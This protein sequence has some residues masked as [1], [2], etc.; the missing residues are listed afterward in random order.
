MTLVSICVCTFRRPCVA[1]TLASLSSLRVP[2][3]IVL[4]IV[5]IDNDEDPSALETVKEAARVSALAVRYVHCP[6]SNIS[7]ARNGALEASQ[8]A[9]LA[10][11][12][13]DEVATP[14]WLEALLDERERTGADIVLGPV[15]ALY[16]D[17]APAWMREERMHSTRPVWV[18]GEIR[19]GYSGNVLFDRRSPALAGLLF[20]PSFGKAGGEDTIFFGAA[21]AAGARIA[22][23]SEA[24]VVEAVPKARVAFGWMARRKFRMGQTH[25]WLMLAT[26][27]GTRWRSLGLAAAKASYCVAACVVTLPVRRARNQTILRFLLHAGVVAGLARGRAADLQPSTLGPMGATGK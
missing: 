4:E 21:H 23:A 16:E 27:Q 7:I 6:G 17:D 2:E 18:D 15:E 25:A 9:L 22:F 3:G 11:I 12:D 8:A 1:D 13:D 20:D 10:F 26:G 5:V 14:G 24:E 19:T